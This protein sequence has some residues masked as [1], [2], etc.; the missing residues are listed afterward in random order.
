MDKMREEFE[1]WARSNHYDTALAEIIDDYEILRTR[2]AWDIWQASRA[3][4][5]VELPYCNNESHD[6][7]RRQI[8]DELD[9][10]GIKYE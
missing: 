2:C 3:A 10:A 7:Y 9:K 1:K 8:E 4:L 6:Q 5:V